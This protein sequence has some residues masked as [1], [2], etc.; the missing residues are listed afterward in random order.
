MSRVSVST[1]G[2]KINQYDS[3]V[4]EDLLR[5]SGHTV[6]PFD[7]PSDIYII[8][9]CTVT[10]R[11]DY[12]AR[13]MIRKTRR[14]SPDAV[15]V[16]TGCYAQVGYEA[17]AA[18]GGVDYIIGNT[19]KV[20][21]PGRIEELDRQES[22]V[23]EV[24]PQVD[25]TGGTLFDIESFSGHTRA[26]LKIQDGCNAACAYCIIPRARGR[27]RSVPDAQVLEGL[28][29]FKDASFREVV[30]CGIHLGAYGL[31]LDTGT[32]LLDLLRLAE[33]APTPERIRLSSI[34]PTEISTELIELI[35][36]SSKICPHLHIPLQ[37]GDA[38]VLEAMNRRYSPDEFH[39]L[40]MSIYRR[41]PQIAIGIDVISGF[42]GEGDAAFDNTVK[43]LEALPVAYLHV[44]PYSKRKG[45][46]ASM[47]EDQV[48]PETIHNRASALRALSRQKRLAYNSRFLGKRLPSLIERKRDRRTGMMQGLTRNYMVVIIEGGD[49]LVGEEVV[50]EV[51]KADE[52][53]VYGVLTGAGAS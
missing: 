40:I 17:I 25:E 48:P 26:F 52:R 16:V 43:L 7:G 35:R 2:C 11:T 53:V 22:P 44:F 33:E 41:I 49:E 42:P 47:R 20:T 9:T 12:K 36:S 30:L 6:A 24:D 27:S 34:E 23:I 15:V 4:L 10:Q 1:L 21:L 19:G 14:R 32:S 46:E 39:D 45:T 51:V 31:D 37:S 8:N 38:R 28:K 5:R 13:Q 29:R 18:I 50:V 3:A